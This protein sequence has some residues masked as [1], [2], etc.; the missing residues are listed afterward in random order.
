MEILYT[1]NSREVAEQVAKILNTAAFAAAVRTF[2]TEISVSLP[3]PMRDIL[4]VAAAVSSNDWVEL[5]L[6]L[7]TLQNDY[8]SIIE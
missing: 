1:Q 8:L 7:S 3:K 5:L 2:N 4:V 6:L